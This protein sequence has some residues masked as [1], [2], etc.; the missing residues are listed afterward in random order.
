M[1][2]KFI[3]KNY[4]S[5]PEINK[6]NNFNMIKLI[7]KFICAL[8][9]LIIIFIVKFFFGLNIYIYISINYFKLINKL[10]LKVKEQKK[11]YVNL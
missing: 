6:Y 2:L 9:V 10:C 7:K 1:F 8:I 5:S 11:I 4:F 3:F